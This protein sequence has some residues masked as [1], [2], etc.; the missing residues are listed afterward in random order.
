MIPGSV[1]V[2]TW[3][4]LIKGDIRTFEEAIGSVIYGGR[5]HSKNHYDSVITFF[6][7]STH[8]WHSLSTNFFYEYS[9]EYYFSSI[10]AIKYLAGVR[11][12]SHGI[13]HL[14]DK[15][16][17]ML[18]SSSDSPIQAID[19]I[20]GSAVFNSYRIC[21]FKPSHE[22]FLRYL[23][24]E[25]IGPQY[26]KAYHYATQI[27]EEDA[28]EL[29]SPICYV[30]LQKPDPGKY[31]IDVI[32]K[33]QTIKHRGSE[34]S[35]R[36]QENPL[37]FI[38]EVMSSSTDDHL[39]PAIL[40]YMAGNHTMQHPI[41]NPYIM[42]IAQITQASHVS[43]DW[44]EDMFARPYHFL[45]Q[46][47][48]N[49][50]HNLMEHLFYGYG[51]QT[52]AKFV[53]VNDF[54]SFKLVSPIRIHVN[55]KEAHTMHGP[56][57]YENPISVVF[58][59]LGREISNDYLTFVSNIT[60][61]FGIILAIQ[62]KD[63]DQISTYCP[64]QQ[65]PIYN[66]KLCVKYF[67]FPQNGYNFCEFP[68]IV[69][70]AG[71]KLGLLLCD[72]NLFPNAHPQIQDLPTDSKHLLMQAAAED[73][74]IISTDWLETGFP[75]RLYGL[76][77]SKWQVVVADSEDEAHK[78]KTALETLEQ[79]DLIRHVASRPGYKAYKLTLDGWYLAEFIQPICD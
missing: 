45:R 61:L 62:V 70:S 55:P 5:A 49:L 47:F 53:P 15:A 6:H 71:L 18:R 39:L 41:L 7:E 31:F 52:T 27:L 48:S 73:S 60:A 12:R 40:P 23:H 9:C 30:A 51:G 25:P 69:M 36:I 8:F 16:N 56:V 38:L 72:P 34:L 74:Q 37:S 46:N 63:K 58:A 33:I 43:N 77:T 78:W 20:E 29:F 65:C 68:E 22:D 17:Q 10:N 24:D 35:A 50:P 2:S 44:A 54:N 64:H 59:G 13:S 57:T 32:S 26:K 67:K 4:T 75:P 19:V 76:K 11:G 14:F 79:H 3:I 1:D 28:F 21:V 42:Y 66:T